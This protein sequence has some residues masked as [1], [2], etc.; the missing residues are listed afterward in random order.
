M[1]RARAGKLRVLAGRAVV[2]VVAGAA[3]LA[4]LAALA[5]GCG[6]ASSPVALVAGQHPGPATP[7]VTPSAVP[8]LGPL[9]FGTFPS[10]LSGVNALALCEDWA[11]LRGQYAARVRTETPYQ[12]EQWFSSAAWR[13]AF[14]ANTPLRV[15]PGYSQISTAFGLA[16]TGQSASIASARLLDKACAAA[17]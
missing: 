13:P 8:V 17:D 4:A 12:L 9:T 11:G 5:V 3:T 16:A 1:L 2:A 6:H 15:D 14:A 10:T 7:T